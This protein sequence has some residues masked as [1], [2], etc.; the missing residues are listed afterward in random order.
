MDDSY[1]SYTAEED[2]EQSVSQEE[3][4]TSGKI[5]FKKDV[6]KQPISRQEYEPNRPTK[7]TYSDSPLYPEL[8]SN[9]ITNNRSSMTNKCKMAETPLNSKVT[10]IHKGGKHDQ[11]VEDN[12]LDDTSKHLWIIYWIVIP[13][14]IL[15]FSLI[16]TYLSLNNSAEVEISLKNASELYNLKK[17]F[18]AQ[19]KLMWG[20]I[21][22]GV[23]TLYTSD[24]KR[25][26][27]LLLLV[28]ETMHS[29]THPR[30]E[31]CIAYLVADMVI[32]QYNLDSA[33]A[34]VDASTVNATEYGEVTQDFRNKLLEHKALILKNVQVMNW[35]QTI[36]SNPGVAK[37]GQLQKKPFFLSKYKVG[38]KLGKKISNFSRQQKF[39]TF[40]RLLK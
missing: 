24:P 23:N 7:S 22:S 27:I 35:N 26:F 29:S 28:N 17:D 36:V 15:N 32:K 13:F 14:V 4:S 39:L 3:Q 10:G 31:E 38:N 33:P 34:V 9:S 12:E 6:R 25:P 1:N 2:S 37:E 5:L 20:A 8:H 21:V 16:L 40:L 18:P 19:P 11:D 30:T